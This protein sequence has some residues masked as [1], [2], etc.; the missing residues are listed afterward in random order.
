MNWQLY[1]FI[2]YAVGLILLF[3][4]AT[5]RKE[6][7][8]KAVATLLT[9]WALSPITAPLLTVFILLRICAEIKKK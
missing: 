5:D 2:S 6:E 7:R 1:L 4:A 8:R 3:I 9:V